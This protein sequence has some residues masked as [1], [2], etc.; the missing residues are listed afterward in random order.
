[1][2]LATFTIAPFATQSYYFTFLR[3]LWGFFSKVS[4]FSQKRKFPGKLGM[5]QLSLTFFNSSW[6]IREQCM[7]QNRFPRDFDPC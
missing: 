6:G 7:L 4:Y 5:C 3:I 2:D 1:M